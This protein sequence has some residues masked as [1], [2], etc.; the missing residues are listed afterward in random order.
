M[1]IKDFIL[2]PLKNYLYLLIP[3]CCIIFWAALSIISNN[4]IIQGYDYGGFYDAFRSI[5]HNIT[6]LYSMETTNY[7]YLPSFAIVFSFL[8]LFSYS[9]SCWIFYFISIIFGILSVIEFNKICKL[10]NISKKLDRFLFLIIISNGY[11]ILKLFDALQS[12]F[13]LLFL[14]LL[15]LRR[16]IELRSQKK[17][18]D[19]IK[20]FFVQIMILI[21]AVGI[22]PAFIFL[23]PI[24]IFS[25]I[26]FKE[27]F[28]KV[29][30]EKY[31]TTIIAFFIQNFIFLVYPSLIFNLLNA[32]TLGNPSLFENMPISIT[33]GLIKNSPNGFD[34]IPTDGFTCLYYVFINKK[35]NYSFFLIL[36]IAIF[37]FILTVNKNLTIEEKFGYH[38]FLILFF[39]LY[40]T[41]I[42]FIAIL[43]PIV[44]LF[45]G[46]FNQN[47]KGI[48]EFIRKNLFI[49]IGSLSI[50]FI[51]F[52]PNL[53]F[54][55]VRFPFITT[56]PIELFILLFPALYAFILFCAVVIRKNYISMLFEKPIIREILKFCIVGA[57]GTLVNVVVLF[58]LVE[59]VFGHAYIILCEIVAFI[60]ASINNYLLNKTWTFKEDIKDQL[61]RKYIIF[62]LTS[63]LALVVNLS[64]L[65]YL[66]ENTNLW[67]IFAEVI[68]ITVAFIVNFLISKFLTFRKRLHKITE[69]KNFF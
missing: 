28:S 7:R 51:Y 47:Y 6:N 15:F 8:G 58:F 3:I 39:S 41:N 37:A 55:L 48:K 10:L 12:K 24:Y 53:Y 42:T 13:I 65:N 34:Y 23:I 9:T 60:I 20:F 35:F 49:I 11:R 21:F 32:S 1:I 57:L 30:L 40:M 27:L 17:D 16:E 31:T 59:I 54:L 64:I 19:D 62:L 56:I 18:R 68:A 69:N 52:Y 4:F 66:I 38:S 29:Q 33:Y 2:K 43:P 26:S 67:Y 25:N 36:V 63:I 46:K 50:S 14:I 61:K 45:I 44:I 22:F 5:L